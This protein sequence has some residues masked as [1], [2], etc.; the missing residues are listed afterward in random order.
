MLDL[1]LGSATVEV[2]VINTTAFL[3]Q[4]PTS[5]FFA[6]PLPKGFDHFDP[7]CYAFLITHK[8]GSNGKVRR[9]LFDLAIRKDFENSR[10]DMVE[11]VK[12]WNAEMAIEKNVSE[13][14]LDQGFDL[15]RDFE[16][17]IWSHSHF[18]HTGD[19]STFPGTVDL[20]VGPG[21]KDAYMPGW[22]A[23][24]NAEMLESCF[25]GRKV[26]EAEFE[27]SDLKLGGFD[28]IDYFGDHSLYLLNTPGVSRCDIEPAS[29]KDVRTDIGSSTP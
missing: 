20:V 23:N 3:R 5:I 1:P 12:K 22:P 28:A 13:I 21:M 26:K 4:V 29:F 7:C 25:K 18:D 14:L 24:K 27:K 6:K 10:P 15:D 11:R 8:D 17:I 2:Q 19:P 16:A 9:L